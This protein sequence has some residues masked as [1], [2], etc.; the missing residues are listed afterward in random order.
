MFTTACGTTDTAKPQDKGTQKAASDYPNR[1]VTLIVAYGP[2]GT[3]TTARLLAAGLEK[4]LGQPVTV[5]NVTG[6]G[7]WTGWGQLANAKPDGYTIGYINV[8]NMFSGYLDPKLK[9]TE[10]LE[11][12]IPIMNHV[13]DA[14]VWIV[15]ADSQFKTLQDLLDY[16]KANPSKVTIACHG[17]GGDDD[18]GRM[19]VEKATGAKFSVIQNTGTADSLTQLLGKHV[20]VVGANVSEV[21]SLQKEGKIRVLGILNDKESEF[22]PGVKTFKEQGID[23]IAFAGRGIAAPAGTPADEIAKI[24]DTLKKTINDPAHQAKAKEM[25][26]AL[27]VKTGADY[28]KF[29]KT[30]EQ[31]V[32]NLMGW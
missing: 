30:N 18:L 7:G 28:A 31:L 8:P 2:G 15:N 24:T 12:F 17:V 19:Q 5:Q 16:A 22:L 4:Q 11:S 23:A 13:T 14:G 32:K 29:L 21:L 9:R 27:D 1:A 10:N 6:G 25:G 26:L 3:D 20:D